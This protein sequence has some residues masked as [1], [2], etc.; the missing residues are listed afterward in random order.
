[1][2]GDRGPHTRAGLDWAET[3]AVGVRA[4]EVVRERGA[5]AIRIVIPILSN[6]SA[7]ARHDAAACLSRLLASG[8]PTTLGSGWRQAVTA[9]LRATKSSDP[10]VVA[11]AIGEPILDRAFLQRQIALLRS[12]V[13]AVRERA[14]V[15][16][17]L[18]RRDVRWS[19]ADRKR[20]DSHLK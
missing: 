18:Q 3:R 13:E 7:F 12:D 2:L 20:I 8:S 1:M 16:L 14:W 6:G 19:R 9:L 11:A 4:R 17:D 15:A 10:F 5:A